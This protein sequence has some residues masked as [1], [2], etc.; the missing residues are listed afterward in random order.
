MQFNSTLFL[1][2]LPT[3]VVLFYTLSK[4]RRRWMLLLASYTFYCVWS[5]PFSLLLVLCTVVNYVAARVISTTDRLL[6]RR[7]CLAASLVTSLSILG[8]FKY[9]DFF[10]WSIMELTGFRPW[11]ELNLILPLGISFY[12]F[13][14]M[15][16]TIDVYRGTTPARKSVLDVA[17]FISFFPQLVAGPII[18][19]DVLVPQLQNKQILRWESIRAGMALVIWGMVKKVYFADTMAVI[20]NEVYASPERFSG[21]ALLVATYAFAIQI[22]CDFSGYTDIAI[23]SARLMGIDLPNN[24]NKPYLS[25]SIQEFWRRWHISLSTWLRDYLYIPL[26]GNRKGNLRMYINIMITM[27]LGGLWHGAGWNWVVWGGI[28][29]GVMCVERLIGFGERVPR[30][31]MGYIMRW[32]VTFHIVCFSWVFFR[33]DS[34]HGALNVLKR[35]ITAATGDIAISTTPLLIL[36]LLL[37]IEILN[38]Q[39]KWIEAF[40]QNPQLVR[41]AG[42]ALTL[43]FVVTFAKAPKPEFIYF[44]F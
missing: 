32:L 1:V 31:L 27:L 15:S 13:Q 8:L 43:L 41:W 12:T 4:E 2:F 5:I 34:L 23:G 28:Q 42:Y 35:I 9:A 16:Y 20:V 11:Q 33:A 44:Q 39:S 3:V 30:S 37:L 10:S 36:P 29:G 38:I 19:A 6:S 21:F 7:L 24:F 25:L 22:Y 40:R 26:G 14:A 18:R 17:L